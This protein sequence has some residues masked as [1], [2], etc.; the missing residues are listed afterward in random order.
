MALQD[1]KTVE[2]FSS[3]KATLY[4]Q[5]LKARFGI[6]WNTKRLIF[7]HSNLNVFSTIFTW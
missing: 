3:A 4:R 2:H 6:F 7:R 1:R 5:K